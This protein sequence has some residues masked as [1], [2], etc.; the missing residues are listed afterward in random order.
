M[1]LG[2]PVGRG[3]F[4][5]DA[6]KHAW[7][8][9]V[10]PSSRDGDDNPC[11]R[12]SAREF[13]F[14]RLADIRDRV[15]LRAVN[16]RPASGSR[17]RSRTSHLLTCTHLYRTRAPVRVAR[18]RYPRKRC[19]KSKRGDGGRARLRDLISFSRGEKCHARL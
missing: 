3:V 16:D 15:T 19:A 6:V 14:A 11:R 18:T 17:D 5:R 2:R 12:L 10:N 8:H 9:G 7:S 1:S 13:H 4:R